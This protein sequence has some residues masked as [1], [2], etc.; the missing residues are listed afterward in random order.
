MGP[1]LLSASF[2]SFYSLHHLTNQPGIRGPQS[3]LH[4]AFSLSLTASPALFHIF[5]HSLSASLITQDPPEPYRDTI[6]AQDTHIPHLQL[7]TMLSKIFTTV[8]LAASLVSAQTFSEC[9]PTKKG[10]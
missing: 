1:G 10:E 3:L 4:S 5:I 9:D 8:A 2:S 7:L 6:L